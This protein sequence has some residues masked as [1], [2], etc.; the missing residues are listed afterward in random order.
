M[1]HGILDAAMPDSPA[2]RFPV[3]NDLQIARCK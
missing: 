3:F 1:L 2:G